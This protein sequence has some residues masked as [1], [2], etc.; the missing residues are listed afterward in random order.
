MDDF[1]Y[2]YGQPKQVYRGKLDANAPFM[3]PM[4]EPEIAPD[5]D[6]P[7]P[8]QKAVRRIV[9]V[10]ISLL[11]IFAVLATTYMPGILAARRN[12]EIRTLPTPT[13]MPRT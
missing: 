5:S 12:A 9:V 13:T 4:V 6:E 7:T 11:L 10:I 3:I 2:E 1:D 8:F